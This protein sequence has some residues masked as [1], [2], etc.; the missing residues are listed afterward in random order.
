MK[1]NIKMQKTG[2]EAEAELY[3]TKS[4]PASDLGV[5]TNKIFIY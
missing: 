1:H 2:A 3:A 5:N 4:T